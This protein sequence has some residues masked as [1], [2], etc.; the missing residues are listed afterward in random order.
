MA[1]ESRSGCPIHYSF[2]EIQEMEDFVY[3]VSVRDER[4]SSE[5]QAARLC[6]KLDLEPHHI[7]RTRQIHSTRVHVVRSGDS[8][9]GGEVGEG[10]GMILAEP[11]LIGAVL[12]ADCLS[13]ALACIESR[14]VALFHAGWRG[15]LKRIVAE[16]VDRF[17]AETGGSPEGLTAL[18][19][20]AMRSCCYQVGE[21][22]FRAFRESG[23][24]LTE[25]RHEDRLDL[26]ALNRRQLE[27]RGVSRI[28]DSQVCTGCG[29]HPFY[30]WR[31][32]RT[33]ERTW[34]ICGF[35]S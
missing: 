15:T 20:P 8:G 22:V 33:E 3:A 35:R 30:S 2:S 6:R 24:D 21:E 9:H 18:L 31:R 19:G 12:T 32:D 16:G 4:W 14:Q 34:V 13:V 7:A 11:G 17:I 5:E 23:H 10:D 25:A 28:L 26:I 1:F 27:A 29:T